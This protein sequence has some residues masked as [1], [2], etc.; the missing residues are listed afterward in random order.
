M[1]T[2]LRLAKE[3]QFFLTFFTPEP[4]IGS[5]DRAS[6]EF[7]LASGKLPPELN[8]TSEEKGGEDYVSV[9]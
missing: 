1:S 8:K 6:F 9:I 2:E 5:G 7:L 4:T 3:P